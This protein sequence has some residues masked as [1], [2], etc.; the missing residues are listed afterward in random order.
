MDSI[1][2][3]CL[4]MFFSLSPVKSQFVGRAYLCQFRIY[5]P[6]AAQDFVSITKQ[7][8]HTFYTRSI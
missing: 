3:E 6:K 5:M 2:D 4:Q 8:I 7:I 1:A